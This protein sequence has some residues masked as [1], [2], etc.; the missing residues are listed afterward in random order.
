MEHVGDIP[1]GVSLVGPATAGAPMLAVTGELDHDSASGLQ[2]ALEQVMTPE[3]HCVL[4]DLSDLQYVD[5]GGIAVFARLVRR[6][7]AKGWVGMIGVRE[8][9][10][11]VLIMTGLADHPHL[12]FFQS[13]DEA[14]CGLRPG[15]AP[16]VPNAR[17]VPESGSLREGDT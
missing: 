2:D 14:A 12:R 1:T 4:L 11:R 6:L 16:P 13:R 7:E 15:A 8:R 17:A 9:V 10:K 3:T 5:S